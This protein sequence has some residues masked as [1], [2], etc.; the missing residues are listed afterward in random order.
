MINAERRQ[1]SLKILTRGKFQ[2]LEHLADR[3]VIVNAFNRFAKNRRARQDFDLRDIVLRK[4]RNRVRKNDLID[5][6]FLQSLDRRTAKNAVRRR[7]DDFRRAHFFNHLGGAADRTA[8]ADHIVEEKRDATFDWAADQVRLF[9][10]GSAVPTLVDNRETSADRRDVF[11]R[12]LNTSGVG[13]H[14]DDFFR[15]VSE[16]VNVLVD[17]RGRGEMIERNIEEALDLRGVEVE[18]ENAIGA[19]AL[20]EVGAKFR[21]NRNATFVF[22]ILARVSEIR[23]H[24]R[25]AIG[26][27][28]TATVDHDEEFHESVVHRSTRRLDNEHVFSANVFF[29]SAETFAVGEMFDDH[30]SPGLVEIIA[31]FFEQWAICS[32]GKNSNRVHVKRVQILSE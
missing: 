1:L 30:F 21:G 29:N 24:R 27:R 20:D 12:A 3:L 6:R 15:T 5:R 32:S 31:N 23:N 11:D 28:A 8:G 26:A 14:D 18:R 4:K 10:F 25:N 9:H 19:G 22:T 2:R 7:D 17:D 13:T 16:R